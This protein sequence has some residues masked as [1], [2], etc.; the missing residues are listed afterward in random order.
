MRVWL[1]RDSGQYWPSVCHY[2]GAAA[3]S[4]HYVHKDDKR[5]FVGLE[6][7][8]VSVSVAFYLCDQYFKTDFA[9]TQLL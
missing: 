8:I 4:L 6:N 1:L 9:V 5:V 2:M 3:T 7:G